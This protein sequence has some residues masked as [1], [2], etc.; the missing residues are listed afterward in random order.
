MAK[1]AL[2]TGGIRGIG[3]AISIALRDAGYIVAANY[4][5]SDERAREFSERTGIAIYKFDVSDFNEVAENIASIVETLGPIDV[6]VNN[7]GITRDTTMHKMTPEQWHAVINTDLGAC[8]N[9]CR[10]VIESM[11]DRKYGR[12]INI[13]SLNGQ[14]GEYGQVNYAA[15][16][17]G[18]HGFNKALALESA[19]YGITV[20]AI[21]PGIIDTD[22]LRAV[23]ENILDKL[24]A[25]VPVGRPG[26]P[27]EI[28][29]AV[30]FLAAEEAS[31]ITGCTL[32]ING[33]QHMY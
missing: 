11:R 12:I 8:F 13:G 26:K 25:K 10:N 21:A 31:F 23:P 2:V 18:I 33:G 7:A 27:E 29:R 6:L 14:A 1:V 19:K 5:S 4:S 3:E 16:K 28:A 17:S 30:V 15:A 24:V 22:M 32:S 9:T 20:N